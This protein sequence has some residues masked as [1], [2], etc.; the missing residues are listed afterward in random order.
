MNT[1][2]PV[3]PE[4]CKASTC[5]WDIRHLTAEQ[6]DALRQGDDR[7]WQAFLEAIHPHLRQITCWARWRFDEQT[8]QEV[9]QV[10]Q[11]ELPGAIQR[12]DGQSALLTFVRRIAAHKCIDEVRRQIQQRQ[13]GIHES[14][15][16]DENGTLLNLIPD[17]RDDADPRWTIE[18]SELSGVLTHLIQSIGEGCH[19]LL[20]AF[21]FEHLSY[22]QLAEYMGISINTVSPRLSKC[23]AKM[24]RAIENNEWLSNYFG[25][26]G[27][28]NDKGDDE[29]E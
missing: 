17:N 1:E 28:W 3:T 20:T 23:Y 11:S 29:H 7:A 2:K 21:Y 27:D 25:H 18:K 22:K 24:R 10:I 9:L 14:L 16:A 8:R 6:H 12:Y 4:P 15:E 13:Q 19:K 26:G 5:L